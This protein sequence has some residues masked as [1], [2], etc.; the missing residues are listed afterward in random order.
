MKAQLKK[1]KD[2][3]AF[4]AAATQ[5]VRL[6]AAKAALEE[7]LAA[8]GH[9]TNVCDWLCC[10]APLSF[11]RFPLPLCRDLGMIK[12]WIS[13]IQ[14][15]FCAAVSQVAQSAASELLEREQF[16]LQKLQ[17]AASEHALKEKM[18]E[19][20]RLEAELNAL[21]DVGLLTSLPPG[22]PSAQ[23]LHCCVSCWF[24]RDRVT[25][26]CSPKSLLDAA[27]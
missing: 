22:P 19:K 14:H 27:Q 21:N 11:P 10:A 7:E 15:T 20:S 16:E 1:Q 2:K 9:V 25:D 18:K 8:V 3:S 24:V 26:A 4:Q 13:I 5:H 6:K 12:G 17:H 23:R